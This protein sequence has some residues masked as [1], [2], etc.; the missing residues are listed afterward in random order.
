MK[1]A[2]TLLVIGFFSVAGAR[3]GPEDELAKEMTHDL[4]MNFNKI[5]PFGKEDTAKELQDHAAK[6]QTPWSMLWRMQRSR[7]SSALCSGRSPACV[8]PPSR[9][10]TPLLAS[11]PRPLTHTMTPITTV[12]KIHLHTCTRTKLP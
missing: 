12:P 4:E 5:A 2:F 11:K 3:K 8:L 6:T 9:S 10:S 1:C 7:R